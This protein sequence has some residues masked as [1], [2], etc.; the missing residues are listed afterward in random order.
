[1]FEGCTCSVK[2]KYRRVRWF[3]STIVRWEMGKIQCY[4]AWARLPL[5]GKYHLSKDLKEESEEISHLDIRGKN[6]LI[7]VKGLIKSVP[8][9]F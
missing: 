9:M 5:I 7:S 2:I 8:G 3:S 4:M 1:M 6:I